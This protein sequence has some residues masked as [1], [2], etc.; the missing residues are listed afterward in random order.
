[1]P[2]V[3]ASTPEDGRTADPSGADVPQITAAMP[4]GAGA[5]AT[6]RCPFCGEVI[7]AMAKKCK[8]CGEFL[9]RAAPPP[10]ATI[11]TPEVPPVFALSVSQWEN[12][13]KYLICVALAVLICGGLIFLAERKEVSA[14]TASLGVPVTLAVLAFVVWMLYLSVKNSRCFIRPTRIDTEV[15]VLSKDINSIELFRITDME[16]KQSVL[17]RILG[18]GTIRISSSDPKTPELILYQ[19][20]KARRVHKYLQDQIPIATK[21]RGAIYYE[22]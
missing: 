17:E 22:R 3:S 14:E 13:W 10:D 18:I 12:F 16:L 2:V 9:D 20:P 8:H 5:D 11:A 4:V 19:I 1:M 6:K 21:Q 7:L 15:G